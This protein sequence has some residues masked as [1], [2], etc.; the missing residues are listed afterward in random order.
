MEGHRLCKDINAVYVTISTTR[1]WESHGLN[2]S[3]ATAYGDL[4]DTWRC[5]KCGGPKFKFS[6]I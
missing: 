5:P 1:W 3:P 6:P 4:P 2:T